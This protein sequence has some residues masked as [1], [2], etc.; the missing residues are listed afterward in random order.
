MGGKGRF[1]MLKLHYKDNR[2]PAIWLVDSR[3]TIGKDPSNN[4]PLGDE[5]ISGFHAELR[6]DGDHIYL[7]DAGSINGTHVND[8]RVTARTQ[9]RAN[10][11]IRIH[12][13]ELCLMD[14]KA[15]APASSDV[16][17]TAISPAL[18]NIPV[19]SPIQ[20]SAWALKAKT[21]SSAG[22][23]YPISLSG[24]SVLGRS[25]E[26]DITLP[27]THVS[28]RHAELFV[29][30]NVLHVKDLGS[31]NGTYVKRKRVETATLSAGNDVRFDTIMFVVIGPEGAAQADEDDEDDKTQFRIGDN[32]ASSAQLPATSSA[33]VQAESSVVSGGE[34]LSRD[35]TVRTDMPRIGDTEA[36]S[37]ANGV[38]VF[39]VGGLLLVSAGAAVYFGLI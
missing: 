5:G 37:S 30:N 23:V 12:T 33:P 27:G 10:D 24:V 35:Y 38:V 31:S 1:H 16:G 26:C 29:Q 17:A 7:T 11:V 9:L 14:P 20:Q 21:G 8:L 34:D 19:S 22:T 6:V 4:I 25:S 2:K 18:S 13:V 39:I 3:Y 28:R 32:G 15:E 36:K